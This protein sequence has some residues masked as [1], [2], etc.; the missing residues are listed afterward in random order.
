[1][2]SKYGKIIILTIKSGIKDYKKM[3]KGLQNRCN[4]VV[5]WQ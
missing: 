5:F 2:Y 3:T 4:L 1:M